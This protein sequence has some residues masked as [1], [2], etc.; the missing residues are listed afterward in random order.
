VALSVARLTDHH[1]LRGEGKY[2]PIALCLVFLICR[3]P[4]YVYSLH[5]AR[6][7]MVT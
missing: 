3:Q 5:R 6:M 1:L 2:Y 4:M 7:K